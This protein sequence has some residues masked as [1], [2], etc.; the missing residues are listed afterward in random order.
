MADLY[1]NLTR[2]IKDQTNP[3]FMGSRMGSLLEKTV[4]KLFELGG[5]KPELNKVINGY[6]IDVYVRYK[7]I[8]LIIECKQY[9]KSTLALRN[10]IHQWDSKNKEI[11]ATKVL[12]VVVGI[13]ISERDLNLAKK[14]GI[15][16]WDETKLSELL[17]E[18]IE[19]RDGVKNK[20]LIEAGLKGTKELNEEIKSIMQKYNCSK[21]EAIKILRGELTEEKLKQ[22]RE[23]EKVMSNLKQKLKAEDLRLFLSNATYYGFPFK[24]VFE[25]MV[26]YK[27]SDKR[28]ARLFVD[29]KGGRYKGK[30]YSK[31]KIKKMRLLM[32]ELGYS[33]E[34][35]DNKDIDKITLTNL[36]RIIRVLKARRDITFEEAKNLI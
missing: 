12:L 13:P 34:E 24:K 2:F 19:K 30:K 35:A 33:F 20:I 4:K 3:I 5:F 16:I 8:D 22:I 10:L 7:T 9:E 1:L 15:T 14:Y 18:A 29:N 21:T 11:K 25:M 27:I 23:I 31:T 36:R 26:K 6:E 28:V 32:D 17:D